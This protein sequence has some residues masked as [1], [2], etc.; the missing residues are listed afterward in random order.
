MIRDPIV[1]EV[2]EA[3]QKIMTECDSSLE[4]LL[5]RLKSAE[6]QDSHRVVSMQSIRK[7][8]QADARL[9]TGQS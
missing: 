6:A 8:R 7:Q 2:R 3:R 9:A 5:D 1:D 4:K